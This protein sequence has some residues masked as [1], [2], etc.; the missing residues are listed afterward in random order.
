MVSDNRQAAPEDSSS[1]AA[2]RTLEAEE[3]L[4]LD[5][6]TFIKEI[7]LMSRKGSALKHYLYCRGTQLVVPQAAAEEY[8]RNLAKIA[9]DKIEHIQNELRW[10]AQFCDG[11]AG[12]AAPGVDVIEGRAKALAAGGSLGALLLLETDDS[13]ARA[14]RRDLTE[15]PPSHR[16][17]SLGDCRI[18]E[19]CLELLLNHNVVFVAADKDFRSHRHGKLLHP[20]LRAEADEVGAGRSLTFHADMES[21]LRELKSEIPPIPD[22]AIFQFVYEADREAIREIQSNSECRPTATG[23]IKQTRLATE[24]RD[25]IEVRLEVEDRWES[26]DGTISSRFELSGSCRFHLGSR[27]LADLRTDALNLL[28][29]EPDGSVRAVKGSR[30]HFQGFAYAGTPRMRPEHGTL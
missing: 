14:R 30:V 25:V 20:Q 8:E 21:L 3:V 27:H 16:G 9:N 12:W 28:L 4:V 19:Q 29:T 17:A 23:T 13:R 10:L 11:V 18:W 22:D 7:G 6:S 1:N 26:P 5:S 2:W 15:R 24:A